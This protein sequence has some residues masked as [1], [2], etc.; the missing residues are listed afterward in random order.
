M[1]Q[2]PGEIFKAYDI[3]GAVGRTLTPALVES[4][5]RA[6]GSEARAR[7]RGSVA[8]GRDGRLSS[9]EL[10]AAAIRGLLAALVV[11]VGLPEPDARAEPVNE[12]S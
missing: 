1:T 3:R 10:A 9:P 2:M 11:A 7:G 6:V 8:V 4:V 12:R 5:G